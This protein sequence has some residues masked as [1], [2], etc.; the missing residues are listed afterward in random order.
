MQKVNSTLNPCFFKRFIKMFL[1]KFVVEVIH[2][3]NLAEVIHKSIWS[4]LLES[5]LLVGISDIFQVKVFS[6]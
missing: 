3:S 6:P 5:H 2:Y 4:V 1:K